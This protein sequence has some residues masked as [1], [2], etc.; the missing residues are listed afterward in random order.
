MLGGKGK[1]AMYE[2][3]TREEAL[4]VFDL[5]NE[6]DPSAVEKRYF[7]LSKRFHTE[8][9]KEKITE[10]VAAYEV[11]NGTAEIR[12]QKEALRE[13]SKKYFGKTAHEWNVYLGYTWRRYV[14]IIVALIA[15]GSVVYTSVT[16]A[17]E[18]LRVAVIGHFSV[19]NERLV[20]FAKNE[21]GFRNPSFL[22]AD[23][24]FDPDV[25]QNEMTMQGPMIAMAHLSIKPDIILTDRMSM[26]RYVE[27]MEPIDDFYDE[28]LDTL[29]AETMEK[30]TPIRAKLADYR[31]M[32]TMEGEEPEYQPGDFDE[33]V[34]G[35]MITDP[36][37]IY[38]YGFLSLWP[39]YE[40]PEEEY[41]P[42][43]RDPSLI[44]CITNYSEEPGRGERF[45]KDMLSNSSYFM[46]WLV[47]Q[48]A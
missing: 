14:L 7:I 37:L 2:N 19:D 17:P 36:E 18:D 5:P 35:L 46:D 16:K 33:H 22:N 13:Q 29:P 1:S 12:R 40:K 31:D 8:G 38:A 47:S 23:V 24:V 43:L 9:E 28:L 25:E 39:P 11:L 10:L 45:V 41:D 3:M 44:F 42:T 26:L 27:A 15:V 30:I 20:D 4:A 48:N 32:T 34:F 6:A 21:K